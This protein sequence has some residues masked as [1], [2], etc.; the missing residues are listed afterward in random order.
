MMVPLD[1]Q[2]GWPL[3]DVLLGNYWHSVKLVTECSAAGFRARNQGCNIPPLNI[4]PHL[5]DAFSHDGRCLDTH[6]PALHLQHR[7]ESPVT[8]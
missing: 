1:F 7:Y 6:I 8:Q 4:L 3:R 5:L 2:I